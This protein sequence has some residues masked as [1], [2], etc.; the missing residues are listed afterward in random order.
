MELFYN[1]EHTTCFNY[2]KEADATFN[3]VE[4][5]K[6]DKI[7]EKYI[8]KNVLVFIISGHI[9]V[10]CNEYQHREMKENEFA[11]LP[12]GCLFSG[13]A[14]QNSKIV[15]CAFY[16]EINLCSRYSLKLLE[17]Y[18][19]EVK[20]DFYILP[21][22]GRMSMFLKLLVLYLEDGINCSHFHEQKKYELFILI[23]AYYSKENQTRIFYPIIGKSLDFKSFILENA[24]SVNCLEEFA[25]RLNCSLASFKRQFAKHFDISPYQWLQ[26][27]KSARIFQ[28][29]KMTE[30]SFLEI[31]ME[32]GFSSQAHFCK[33]CKTQFGNTP[34]NIRNNK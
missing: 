30:K 19:K 6:N 1:R 15:T 22:A 29:I 5:K 14:L 4:F 33:F 20:P 26:N 2:Q 18:T 28:E 12:V 11:L 9:K 31:S 17:A 32:Y 27:Q 10:S 24:A 34:K 25:K 3:F 13:E 7:M 16:Q 8:G 23:R 21:F